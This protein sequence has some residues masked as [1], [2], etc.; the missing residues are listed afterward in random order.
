MAGR[1]QPPTVL[2]D[3]DNGGIRF[4]VATC[5]AELQEPPQMPPQRCVVLSSSVGRWRRDPPETPFYEPLTLDDVDQ[6]WQDYQPDWAQHLSASQV[7]VETA[8]HFVHRD[9]PGLA[10]HVVQAVM[11]AARHGKPL[12]LDPVAV[13]EAGD[14]V[15]GESPST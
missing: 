1:D 8:G 3:S 13:A 7:I 12:Q 2:K 9:A 11:A 10:A 5:F 4:P 15:A 14:Y 6:L